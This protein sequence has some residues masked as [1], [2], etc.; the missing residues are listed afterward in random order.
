MGIYF[1]L[2]P[3]SR[4]NLVGGAWRLAAMPFLGCFW[5]L[6]GAGWGSGAGE[7][8]SRGAGVAAGPR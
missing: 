6:R 4:G 8:G 7:G 1:A 3:F 2:V 5:R